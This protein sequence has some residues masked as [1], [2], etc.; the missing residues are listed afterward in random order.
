MMEFIY[1][2]YLIYGL[3]CTGKYFPDYDKSDSTS[4]LIAALL[5]ILFWPVFMGID[6]RT[7]KPPNAA[8]TS[9]NEEHLGKDI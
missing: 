4:W 7:P 5:H 3:Y 8:D 1:F 2:L 6:K 9:Q